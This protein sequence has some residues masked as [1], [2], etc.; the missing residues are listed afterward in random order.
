MSAPSLS[1]P[2][3]TLPR[4]WRC[5]GLARGVGITLIVLLGTGFGV[6]VLVGLTDPPADPL[7]C[8]IPAVTCLVLIL[9]LGRGALHPRIVATDDGLTV[10]N[11]LRTVHVRW[12]EIVDVGPGYDGLRIV[13]TTGGPVS[14]WAVQEANIAALLRRQTRSQ[15]IAAEIMRLATD[16]KDRDSPTGT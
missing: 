6:A 3:S 15:V 12:T 14:A 5:S 7:D 9:A 4:S 16:V 2:S 11:P 8:V 13:R 10:H 1:S